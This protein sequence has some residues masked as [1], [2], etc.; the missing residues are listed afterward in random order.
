[1]PVGDLF[2]RADLKS[3]PLLRRDRFIC[4]RDSPCVD[5][6]VGRQFVIGAPFLE[7]LSHGAGGAKDA[8]VES[9]D[10]SESLDPREG[11][12]GPRQRRRGLRSQ[13]LRTRESAI[14][15]IHRSI[16]KRWRQTITKFLLAQSHIFSLSGRRV[17][18]A[19]FAQISFLP[20]V[21]TM[22][23]LP[24]YAAPALD[25]RKGRNFLCPAIAR[26]SSNG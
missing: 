20:C 3:L 24:G 22:K 18:A 7:S 8:G 14:E 10:E 6:G 26:L 16:C 19:R 17:K 15:Q 13:S 23:D 12:V 1:M 11:R 21:Q 25:Q 9:F 2:L 5:D 4:S